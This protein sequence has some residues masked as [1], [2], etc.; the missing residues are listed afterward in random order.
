MKTSLFT[1]LS[2]VKKHDPCEDGLEYA[3]KRGL[4]DEPFNLLKL[5]DKQDGLSYFFWAWKCTTKKESKV[6]RLILHDILARVEPLYRKVYPD[7]TAVTDVLKALK[8]GKGLEKARL[9]AYAAS[10]AAV[11]AANASV[12][13]ADVDIAYADVDVA[14]AAVY[15]ANA[16]VSAGNATVSAAYSAANAINAAWYAAAGTREVCD[17]S[18]YIAEQKAQIAIIRRYLR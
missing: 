18:V 5:L 1:T 3:L 8:T 11:D 10:D 9:A 7:S 4:S 15:A 14:Y 2:K 13:V 16:A 17:D 12:N 6:M